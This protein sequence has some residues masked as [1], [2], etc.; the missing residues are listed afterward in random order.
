MIKKNFCKSPWASI[1]VETDGRV[2]S[3]C[4]GDFYWGDLNHNSL[5]EILNSA[6]VLEIKQGIINDEPV[7]YCKNCRQDEKFTGTSQ[8]FY[9]DY[10]ELPDDILNSTTALELKNIDIRWNPLCNMACVYCRPDNSTLWQQYMKIPI[11]SLDRT[12]YKDLLQLVS[13]H[14]ET[15]DSVFLLGGEP[16]IQ[17]QNIELLKT[18][19]D[20]CEIQVV[21]NLKANLEKNLVFNELKRKQNVEW[22]LSF[23]NV[24]ERFEYVRKG[25]NWQQQIKNIEILKSIPAHK[26]TL[27]GVYC[28]H[29]ALNLR[30]LYEFAHSADIDIHLQQLYNPTCLNILNFSKEIRQKAIDEIDAVLN[31]P[32][33][34]NFMEK[35]QIFLNT[36]RQML[37]DKSDEQPTVHKEFC[38]WIDQF[39][40]M[41]KPHKTFDEL[42]PELNQ[43]IRQ[44]L[45]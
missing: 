19:N 22:N 1:F 10:M 18:L 9:Y 6:T 35:N 37:I 13:T 32:Y 31:L 45:I 21:T 15:I 40:S 26:V 38:N 28:V 17:N 11:S 23:E 4:P 12:Y 5:E 33:F 43:L 44:S 41:A 14:T 27:L 8:R 24:G 25:G 16:L 20:N 36:M 34:N 30:E 42:W 39:E 2:K 7:E 3:C 29:S